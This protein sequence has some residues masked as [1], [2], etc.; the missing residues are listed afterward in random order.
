MLSNVSVMITV[1]VCAALVAIAVIGGVVYLT[2]TGH[3]AAVLAAIGASLIAVL[4]TLTARV[5]SLHADVKASQNGG[6]E[7]N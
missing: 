7:G 4:S 3:D 1:V 6:T 5:K 2:V